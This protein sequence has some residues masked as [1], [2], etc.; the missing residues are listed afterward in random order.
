MVKII[1][2]N[3]YTCASCKC[4]DSE[5]NFCSFASNYRGTV[6]AAAICLNASAAVLLP[7]CGT[8]GNNTRKC[9][10][11]LQRQ[12]DQKSREQQETRHISRPYTDMHRRRRRICQPTEIFVLLMVTDDPPPAVMTFAVPVSKSML[13]PRPR[14]TLA[15]VPTPT[16]P[17]VTD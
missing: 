5:N 1:K 8:A 6:A 12:R 14:S 7:P 17:M 9:R 13:A 2:K 4:L 16:P 3:V 11:A 15:P 10:W